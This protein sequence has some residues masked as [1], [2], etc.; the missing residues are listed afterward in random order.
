[1][2][3]RREGSPITDTI[4]RYL[5]IKRALGCRFNTEERSLRMFDRFLAG[6]GIARTD[7]I[8]GERVDRFLASRPRLEPRSF[9]QLLGCV[10]RLFEWIVEQGELDVSPVRTP[11]RRSC[12]GIAKGSIR[13]RARLN[14]LSTFLG[15]VNP[16][17]T[18]VYLT[19]TS[20]LLEVANARFEA[21]AAP[22]CQGGRP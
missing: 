9:N 11:A 10:R 15:H 22:P 16:Q 7:Q 21:Y 4:T 17:S 2:S 19:I 3:S 13:A 6:Q 20:E 1:V 12:A 14:H 5:K 18:A 8:T